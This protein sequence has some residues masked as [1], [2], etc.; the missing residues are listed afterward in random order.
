MD[1]SERIDVTEIPDDINNVWPRKELKALEIL[2]DSENPRL[3]LIT[4]SSQSEIRK[5]LLEQEDVIELLESILDNKGLFPGEDIIVIKEHDKYKVLEGNRRVCAVQCLL[6]PSLAP[7]NFRDEVKK[8]VENSDIDTKR[9]ENLSALVAPSWEAAQKTITARH[10]HYRIKKWA[11]VLK[12][13]RDFK[14]F[15]INHNVDTVS[16]ILGEDKGE[17]I[18]NLKNYAY[19]RYILDIPSWTDEEKRNLS[20]NEMK[21]SPLQ[22][23]M[24]VEIQ[25]LLGIS[26]DSDL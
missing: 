19:V 1:S 3:N 12:W 4:N 11:Y 8:L 21:A 16:L 5:A 13:R 7:I 17:I 14:Q 9:M 22:W 24:S 10:T 26:F 20:N 2:L 6:D 23:H 15:Q 18:N 25:S